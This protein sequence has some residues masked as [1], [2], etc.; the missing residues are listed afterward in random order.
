MARLK[1]KSKTLVEKVYAPPSSLAKPGPRQMSLVKKYN[2]AKQ[3][4]IKKKKFVIP[5]VSHLILFKSR[6]LTIQLTNLKTVFVDHFI[7]FLQVNPDCLYQPTKPRRPRKAPAS[8]Y[9]PPSFPPPQYKINM[10]EIYPKTRSGRVKSRGRQD[11]GYYSWDREVGP[12]IKVA[13]DDVGP[14]VYAVQG[15]KC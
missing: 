3:N 7:S 14:L 5:N 1:D 13:V 8:F 6:L 2:N 4:K 15:G 11:V 12:T 9:T 10:R